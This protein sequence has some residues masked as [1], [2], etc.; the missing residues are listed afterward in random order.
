MLFVLI[1]CS[2]FFFEFIV[3]IW[4]WCAVSTCLASSEKRKYSGDLKSKHSKSGVTRNLNILTSVFECSDFKGCWICTR[5][6]GE[7]LKRSWRHLRVIPYLVQI[8]HD[9]GKV[10][11]TIF[12]FQ[13][14]ETVFHRPHFQSWL[15]PWM[16]PY[17]PVNINIKW[18]SVGIQ[19]T[20]TRNPDSP[21][22]QTF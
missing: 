13:I 1:S 3:L 19:V 8:E 22:Y 18:Y 7:V 16:L 20:D 5:L 12:F 11:N 6:T 21:E 2:Y 17:T 4:K 9:G 14:H 15:V 10:Y